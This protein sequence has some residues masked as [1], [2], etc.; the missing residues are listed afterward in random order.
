LIE[1]N[2]GISP[3]VERCIEEEIGGALNAPTGGDVAVVLA[4]THYPL[5]R[6]NIEDVIRDRLKPSTMSVFD[7]SAVLS[8]MLGSKLSATTSGFVRLYIN[9]SDSS[10]IRVALQR[11][12]L[13]TDLAADQVCLGDLQST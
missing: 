11:F 5:V 10:T 3:L 7:P 1:A 8:D 4:C 12:L 2:G 6:Q 9:N 13:F